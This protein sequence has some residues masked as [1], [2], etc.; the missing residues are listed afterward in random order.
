[1]RLPAGRSRRSCAIH[2]AANGI[3]GTTL[4]AGSVTANPPIRPPQDAAVTD[5]SRDS[6]TQPPRLRNNIAALGVVQIS[7]YLIPLITLPYLT[8]ILG[9]EAY[10][11]VAF[12]QVLM[13]YFVMLTDFGFSWSA[14]RKIS[15]N[16]SDREQV[17][18][19]FVGT[20]A[21]Q[22]LLV[23][24]AAVLATLIVT[25]S[26][27]LRPDAPL[28]AAA[29]TTV[30]GNAM[31]P[32]WFLQGLERLQVVATLQVLTRL[33]ALIPIFTLIKA[34][35]DFLLVPLIT[36]AGSMLGGTSALI[37]IRYKRLADWRWLGWSAAAREL[38]HGLPLFGSRLSISLYTTL[39]PLVLGWFAGP[40]AV[41][42]FAVADKLRNAL[43][44]AMHPLSQALFPRMARLAIADPST[45]NKLLRRAAWAILAIGGAGGAFLFALS[46][47]VLRI[48]AG[49]Q[50]VS[51]STTLRL[52]AFMPMIIHLSSLAS[53]QVLLAHG[54]HRRFN[55]IIIGC[56]LAG[57]PFL[58]F[59]ST[60]AE[61]SATFML[62]IEAIIMALMI[63]SARTV[64]RR[65]KA[66]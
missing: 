32:I 34:P 64:L 59:T 22:W 6:A 42:H 26:A 20:W 15:A 65:K 14:T 53:V 38:Q 41:A 60:T 3:A 57:L 29:F 13:T 21:A 7:N 56:S 24:A 12:A 36:G 43:Q 63:L 25:F 66:C 18:R 44:S 30:L 40:V 62:V 48:I 31:F 39:V 16:R 37:W 58:Y 47:P 55:T 11:R 27:R 5:Q 28:Y 61:R 23:L 17:S 19:I 45:A 54:E 4:E 50:F 8:R 35:S 51:A 33:L 1:L 9:P 2:D 10:G 52:M 46:A 49:P